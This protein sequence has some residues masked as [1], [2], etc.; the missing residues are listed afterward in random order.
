MVP[1][2][3]PF[4]AV[5][6]YPNQ[7]NTQ[8]GPKRNTK[9]QTLDAFDEPIPHL[10]NVSECGA[11]YAWVYNGGWNIAEAMITGFWAGENSVEETAWDE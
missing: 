5:Q 10:Y 9:A 1:L 8:G 7:Y 4:Y 3:G 6:V 11:G 2:E